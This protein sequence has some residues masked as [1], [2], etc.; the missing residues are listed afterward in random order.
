M[1]EKVR[2]A[3]SV[4][5]GAGGFDWGFHRAGFET[6]LAVELKKAP[7]DTLAHNLKLHIL[8]TPVAP[9]PSNIPFVAVGD[10]RTVDFS[11]LVNLQ[12]DVLIG[13]PPCQDF[14][15]S[16]G[17]KREGLNG[18]RGKLYLEFLRALKFLQP[19]TFVFE[20]V[21]GFTSANGGLAYT[22]V[23]DDLRNLEAHCKIPLSEA[24]PDQ[25]LQTKVN[26]YDIAYSG[27]VDAQ[28]LGVPQTRRRLII[29]GIRSDLVT[30][31]GGVPRETHILVEN[32][33][34]G[35]FWH[36]RKFPLTSLEIMEGK[37]LNKLQSEY[38]RVME[39]YRSLAEEAAFIKAHVWCSSVWRKLTFDVVRDYYSANLL[40]YEADYDKN[41]F[42]AAMQE[43]ETLLKQ[44]GWLN[45]PVHNI[46][47][48]QNI[49]PRQSADV[50]DRMFNIPPEEN[51][52]FVDGTQWQVESKKISFIYRRP[53]PLKP[54]WT[55]MAHGGGGTYGYHY[56]RER[57]MLT[58]RER[59]RIQTFSDDFEFKPPGIRAQIGEA[60][61]PLLGERIASALK[62]ILDQLDL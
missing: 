52:E 53:S 7:A 6:L 37:P 21:P 33:L 62:S 51:A 40:N 2:T 18:G 48:P 11:N 20:N 22:T 59:A 30:S 28:A 19:K 8:Q 47:N 4:F 39:S 54:A 32:I 45:M 17:S 13:G 16:K 36:F 9:K 29:I 27:I 12:P 56:E 50:I 31:I 38:R 26:G 1:S 5:S 42:T 41:E 24:H 25:M 14:S 35:S 3:A 57:Q 23:L 55:V 61:P 15:I 10:I 60:V 43:H 46:N 49:K 44:L 34:N 58:I